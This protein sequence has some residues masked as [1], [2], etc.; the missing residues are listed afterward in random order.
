MGLVQYDTV[1]RAYPEVKRT[2]LRFKD[3][4]LC[5]CNLFAIMNREGRQL[6]SFWRKVEQS[7]KKPA[8]MLA[9]V[10]GIGA[11]V[12]YLFN[13]LSLERALK[14]VSRRL[15]VRVKPVILPFARAGIDVDTVKDK[16]LVEKI[17]ASEANQALQD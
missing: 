4:G 12:M 3:R 9:G 7:R 10:L 6:V 5:S 15:G 13:A 2:V 11:V 16:L 17:L 8:K 14:T 1:S